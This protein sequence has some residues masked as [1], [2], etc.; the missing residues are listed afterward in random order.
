MKV[1]GNPEPGPTVEDTTSTPPDALKQKPPDAPKTGAGGEKT[2]TSDETVQLA[3]AITDD[4][5]SPLKAQAGKEAFSNALDGESSSTRSPQQQSTTDAVVDH[6]VEQENIGD[7]DVE[8]VDP[9]SQKLQG[10]GDSVLTGPLEDPTLLLSAKLTAK[11][12]GDEV[13][14]AVL[15]IVEHVATLHGLKVDHTTFTRFLTDVVT[16]SVSTFAFHSGVNAIYIYDNERAVEEANI[17]RAAQQDMIRR[18]PS[19]QIS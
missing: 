8:V 3:D 2:L 5:Q 14:A 16:T 17:K 18:K 9:S 7:L 19:A 4:I 1:N 13:H 12:V 15:D 6:L 10:K 11:E